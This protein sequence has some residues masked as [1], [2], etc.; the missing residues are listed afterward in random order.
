MQIYRMTLSLTILVF[1]IPLVSH[2]DPIVPGT[3]NKIDQ[4]GDNFEDPNWG[5]V[6]NFP[7]SSDEIDFYLVTLHNRGHFVP[8]WARTFGSTYIVSKSGA[9][10]KWFSSFDVAKGDVSVEPQAEVMI[11]RL[12]RVSTESFSRRSQRS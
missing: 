2:A 10:K 5:F 6:H 3:G 9:S 11:T 1:A 12:P 8:G 4:V 7:K